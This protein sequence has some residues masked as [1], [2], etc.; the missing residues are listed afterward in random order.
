MK[1]KIFK[2]FFIIFAIIYTIFNITI[3][4]AS[5]L[6]NIA[7]RGNIDING[8]NGTAV[9]V[10]NIIFG[11]IQ[12]IG[13]IGSVI[14]LM[15]LGIKYMTSSVEEKANLKNSIPTYIFGAT[16]IVIIPVIA[17]FIYSVMQDI[18]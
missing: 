10:G 9:S 14:A 5:G 8:S 17:N 12:S 6:E 1:R 16:L 7:N 11:T 3:V 13:I 4:Q 18:N 2:K 15:I